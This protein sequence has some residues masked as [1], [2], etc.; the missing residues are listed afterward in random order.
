MF[1]FIRTGYVAWPAP[2]FYYK[3]CLVSVDDEE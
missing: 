3:L 1:W 2:P